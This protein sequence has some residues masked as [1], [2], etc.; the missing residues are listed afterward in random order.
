MALGSV[1]SSLFYVSS[2]QSFTVSARSGQ[3]WVIHNIYYDSPIVIQRF[4][5]VIA[6]SIAAR[7][8]AGYIG[9]EFFHLASSH[10]LRFWNTGSATAVATATYGYDGIQ[11][12]SA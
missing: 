2:G 5:G 11:T 6:S 12:N 10:S 4:D 9:G 7:T 1:I 3:E 8:G